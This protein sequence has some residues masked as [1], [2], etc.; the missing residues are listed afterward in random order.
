MTWTTAEDD[1]GGGE[2]ALTQIYK[3]T[4]KQTN[5]QQL[6]QFEISIINKYYMFLK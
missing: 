4:N 6:Q 1:D 3:K 5:K 2:Q